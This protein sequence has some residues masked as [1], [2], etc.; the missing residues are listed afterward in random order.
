MSITLSKGFFSDEVEFCAE[1]GYGV[2]LVGSARTSDFNTT[3][4]PTLPPRRK[5]RDCS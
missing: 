4:R 2:G 3:H 1:F 5:T